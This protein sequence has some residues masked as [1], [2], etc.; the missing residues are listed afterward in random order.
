MRVEKNSK[1]MKIDSTCELKVL[2]AIQF[3]PDD[4]ENEVQEQQT[5]T[6]YR[7]VTGAS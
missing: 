5:W 2:G 7:F 3:V 6:W 1:K 4:E